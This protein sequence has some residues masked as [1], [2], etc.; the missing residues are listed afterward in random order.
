[1]KRYG[2]F[3]EKVCTFDALILSAYKAAKGKKGK[4]TVSRFI[5]NLENEVINLERE[6]LTKK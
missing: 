2:Y 6:L 1:M 3:F 5:Y 4:N